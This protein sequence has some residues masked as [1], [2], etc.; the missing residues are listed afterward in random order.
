VGG[1]GGAAPGPCP[2]DATF[3]SGFEDAGLPAGSKYEPDYQAANWMMFLA[4]DTTVVRTG[5]Q[6]LL[7]KAPSSDGYDYRTL[8][9]PAPGPVFWAR[10]YMRSDVDFGQLGHNSFFS[11]V[12]GDGNPN[13]DQMEVSEQDCQV[14]LNHK[15]TLSFSGDAQSASCGAC[16]CPHGGTVLAHDTW[17]CVEA[18]FDGTNGVVK[19]YANGQMIIDEEAAPKIAYARVNFGY[20]Q[21]HGPARRI[22]YDDVVVAAGRIGCN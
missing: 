10:L 19:V 18:F 7:A 8:S 14:L 16:P 3:C 22:W 2:A 13:N 5:A 12:I 6:S 11:A 15:D 4:L 21:F 1:G 9:V 17:H 20:E